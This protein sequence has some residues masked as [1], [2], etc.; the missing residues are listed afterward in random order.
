[1]TLLFFFCFKFDKILLASL[2]FFFCFCFWRYS[3]IA[4][5]RNSF[6]IETHTQH[7]TIIVIE[8][9][10]NHDDTMTTLTMNNDKIIIACDYLINEILHPSK[11]VAITCLRNK[12]DVI[13]RSVVIKLIKNLCFFS[14]EILQSSFKKLHLNNIQWSKYFKECHSIANPHQ[15]HTNHRNHNNNDNSHKNQQQQSNDNKNKNNNNNNSIDFIKIKELK[16]NLYNDMLEIGMK[17]LMC[18]KFD[19]ISDC[20]QIHG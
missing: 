6:V 12:N 8:C 4:H 15:T 5:I 17:F 13:F 2:I 18:G 10:K 1:M 11:M 9:Q 7:N 19:I 14:N 3:F 20:I 16:S